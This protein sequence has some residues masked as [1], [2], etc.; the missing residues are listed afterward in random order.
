MH[1]QSIQNQLKMY[2]KLIQNVFRYIQSEYKL[3]SKY[4]KSIHSIQSEF[5]VFKV[6]VKAKQL[7]FNHE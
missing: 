4:S 2:S 6:E 7:L 5:I 3:Y 1:S